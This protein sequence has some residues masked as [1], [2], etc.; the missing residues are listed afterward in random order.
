MKC[1][2]G[3]RSSIT[4]ALERQVPQRRMYAKIGQ[5]RRRCT[6][7]YREIDEFDVDLYDR[8]AKLLADADANDVV[9]PEGRPCRRDKH[10]SGPAVG[11]PDLGKLL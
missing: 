8:A 10:G 5:D 4:A 6:R 2:A 9:T 11:I 3:H 1:P 7:E